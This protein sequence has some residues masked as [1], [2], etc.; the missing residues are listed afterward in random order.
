MDLE[1]KDAL[2]ELSKFQSQQSEYKNYFIEIVCSASKQPFIFYYLMNL[3]TLQYLIIVFSLT[4]G[5][6]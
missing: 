6:N 3:I 5:K 2:E 1:M 4:G